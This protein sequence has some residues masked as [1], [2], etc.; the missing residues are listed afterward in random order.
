MKNK[1]KYLILGEV[2]AV[3]GPSGAGKTSL[4][5]IIAGSNI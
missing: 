4:L 3:I 1:I 5:D 2:T